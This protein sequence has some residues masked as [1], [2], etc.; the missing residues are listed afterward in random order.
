MDALTATKQKH[1]ESYLFQ[2]LLL[3]CCKD[4]NF[5]TV[6]N[7]V[8]VPLLFLLTFSNGCNIQNLEK[9]LKF[10]GHKLLLMTSFEKFRRDNLSR[11]TYFNKFH[12]HPH[13]RENLCPQVS[14]FNEYDQ[15][16][17][18]LNKTAEGKSLH[19][20]QRRSYSN[21]QHHISFQTLFFT[22]R[23]SIIA[24]IVQ[25][26]NLWYRTNLE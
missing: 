4:N 13:N 19:Y 7:Q 24:I 3:Q 15:Y 1:R 23:F 9:I 21:L 12:G 5:M 11:M 17:N 2:S 20:Y 6:I 14:S 10:R 26:K 16:V 25:W 18:F 22:S 8:L